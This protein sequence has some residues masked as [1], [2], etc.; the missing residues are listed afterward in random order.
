MLAIIRQ[1]GRQ[2]FE[3]GRRTRI[4]VRAEKKNNMHN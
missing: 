1:V 4:R 3:K 2:C